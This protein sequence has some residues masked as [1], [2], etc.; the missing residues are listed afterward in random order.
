VRFRWGNQ[1]LCAG[2]EYDERIVTGL[3]KRKINLIP[4]SKSILMY[5]RLD[6]IFYPTFIAI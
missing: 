4:R 6:I 3:G 2:L 1:V 5:G